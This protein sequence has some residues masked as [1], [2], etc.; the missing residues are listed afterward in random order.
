MSPERRKRHPKRPKMSVQKK[1]GPPW[2]KAIIEDEGVD[3]S[4]VPNLE[5]DARSK[6]RRRTRRN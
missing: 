5:I 6:K 2:T 3:K 4:A 1:D